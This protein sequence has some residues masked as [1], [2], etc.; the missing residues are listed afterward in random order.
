MN[1]HGLREMQMAVESWGEVHVTVA[2]HDAEAELRFGATEFDFEA[3]V[4]RVDGPDHTVHIS[5]DD[6]VSY[7]KPRAVWHE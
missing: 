2:E 6:V 5:M 3:G 1:E 4:I 7:Y